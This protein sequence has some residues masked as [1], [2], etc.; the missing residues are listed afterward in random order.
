M[1]VFGQQVLNHDPLGHFVGGRTVQLQLPVKG[2]LADGQGVEAGATVEA[3][4]EQEK[5]YEE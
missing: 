5:E 2:R 3:A 4:G 1:G